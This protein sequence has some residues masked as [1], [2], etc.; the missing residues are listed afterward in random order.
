MGNWRNLTKA[1]LTRHDDSAK[2]FRKYSGTWAPVCEMFGGKFLNHPWFE[3]FR[4][5]LNENKQGVNKFTPHHIISVS[6]IKHLNKHYKKIL[7]KSF[8]SVNHPKNLLLL[9]NKASI[10]CEL[11]VP[12]H[13]SSH[14][15]WNTIDKAIPSE[16]IDK[17]R[18][19]NNK[20]EGVAVGYHFYVNGKLRKEIKKLIKRCHNYERKE[21]VNAFDNLSKTLSSEI[22][23]GRLK[24][25]SHTDDYLETG[26]GCGCQECNGSRKHGIY[27]NPKKTRNKAITMGR[28][29]TAYEIYE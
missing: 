15:G 13:E 1:D 19:N 7:N 6:S 25:G 23:S 20:R 27:L 11:K 16:N 9:P 10:A 26:K 5:D 22:T 8:Y 29:K 17:I 4:Y 28:L 12:I 2:G 24:L 14:T 18:T 21:F 3:P